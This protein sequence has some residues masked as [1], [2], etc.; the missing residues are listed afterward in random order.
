[1]KNYPFVVFQT[2]TVSLLLAGRFK[3]FNVYSWDSIGKLVRIP[4]M[5][6]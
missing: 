6:V 2:I 3:Q 1:L 4:A 5:S